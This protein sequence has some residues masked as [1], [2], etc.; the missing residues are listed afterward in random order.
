ML[1]FVPHE[2]PFVRDDDRAA[3]AL[4]DQARD[5]EILRDEPRRRIEQDE[6][7]IAAL[8]RS[9]GGEDAEPLDLARRPHRLA[10]SGRVDEAV[11]AALPDDLHVHGIARRPWRRGHGRAGLAAEP[12]EKRGLADVRATD[13]RNAEFVPRLRLGCAS[14]LRNERGDR[15][16]E[17]GDAEPVLGGDRDRL[18]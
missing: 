5:G 3:P 2:V 8:D 12:V 16:N 17:I 9:L 6:R 15:R 13:D 11:N 10:D 14:V 18:A 1:R 7:D 4:L